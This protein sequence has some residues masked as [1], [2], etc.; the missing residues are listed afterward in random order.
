VQPRRG[1]FPEILEAT[2][3]G[4]L[5]AADDPDALADGLRAIW[6]DPDLAAALGR[7][8]AAGGR[9]P[10]SVGHMAETVEHIYHEVIRRHANS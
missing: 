10:Y 7:A 3:G 9:R 6:R 4:L 5:V 2:G 1:A 8:G